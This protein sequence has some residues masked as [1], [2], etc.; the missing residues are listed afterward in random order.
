MNETYAAIEPQRADIDALAGPALLEIGSPDCGHCRRAQPL[1]ADAMAAHPTLLHLKVFDGRGLPL[2]RSFGVKLWPTL[3]FFR[4]GAKV[5][6]LVRPLETAAI[7][8]ALN[9]IDG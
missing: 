5:S 4:H 3:I 1:I 9:A 6:R 7:A 8:A 2:G